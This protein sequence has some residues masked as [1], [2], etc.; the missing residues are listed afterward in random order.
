MLLLL[1]AVNVAGLVHL[2]PRVRH[3]SVLACRVPI[4]V[5]RRTPLRNNPEGSLHTQYI[6]T[7]QSTTNTAIFCTLPKEHFSSGRRTTAKACCASTRWRI[8]SAV[9]KF[10]VQATRV[11]TDVQAPGANMN[12]WPC[13]IFTLNCGSISLKWQH[14]CCRLF[15]AVACCPFHQAGLSMMSHVSTG[16]H[17]SLQSLLHATSL[18]SAAVHLQGTAQTL[19]LYRCMATCGTSHRKM[20]GSAYVC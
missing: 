4:G 7:E 1:P 2:V 16:W 11:R 8:A 15:I 10:V 17:A 9:K 19:T 6:D 18:R 14:V 13:L 12:R 5:N 3:R 20:S